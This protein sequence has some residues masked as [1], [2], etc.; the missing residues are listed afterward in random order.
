MFEQ[1][2]SWKCPSMFSC[3]LTL[4]VAFWRM[5][6]RVRLGC[7]WWWWWGWGWGWGWR[8]RWW[9]WWWWWSSWWSHRSCF[10]YIQIDPE[11]H[12]VS[13]SLCNPWVSGATG[14]S[15]KFR[16]KLNWMFLFLVAGGRVAYHLFI[17]STYRWLYRPGIHPLPG[18]IWSL[19]V[20]IT[21][22]RNW[23][24]T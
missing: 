22:F 11:K 10:A 6:V 20:P 16:L 18:V 19:H 5:Q 24:N 23:K 8:W 3:R 9:W 15:S 12:T 2:L 21:I 14:T 4:G 13:I 7:C 1:S 17:G